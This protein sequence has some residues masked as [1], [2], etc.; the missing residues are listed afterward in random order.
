MEGEEMSTAAAVAPTRSAEAQR[1]TVVAFDMPFLQLTI[2]MVKASFAAALATLITSVLWIAIG[3]LM[4]VAMMAIGTALLAALGLGGAAVAT[5]AAPTP[6]TA[7]AVVQPVCQQ[8]GAPCSNVD[9]CCMPDGK[10]EYRVDGGPTMAC[11][12]SGC[13]DDSVLNQVANYCKQ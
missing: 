8:M 11:P 13:D 10:C 5:A 3:T 2:F 12:A 7:P 9:M 1:V 4:M 6:T